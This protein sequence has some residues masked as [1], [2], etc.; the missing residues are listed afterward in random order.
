MG[1]FLNLAEKKFGRL[2]VISR[3]GVNKRGNYLWN[4]ICECG[5]EKLLPSDHLIRKR[6]PVTSCG[7][8]RN[9]RIR[10]RHL[11]NETAFRLL[12][13]VYKKRSRYKKIKFELSDDDFRTLTSG[14]C[15]YCGDPPSMVIQNKPKTGSYTYSSI[16]RKHSSEGYTLQNSVPCCK[17][18]NYMKWIFS[19]EEFKARIIKIAERI[20]HGKVESA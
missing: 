14:A 18:C 17:P 1:S 8:Y 19:E 4:C 5:K 16:D 20:R 10:E 3:G 15:A 13:G 12:V 7:C 11:P 2:R 6:K 9:D